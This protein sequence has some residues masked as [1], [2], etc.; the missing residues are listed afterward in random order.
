MSDVTV[1][2]GRRIRAARLGCAWSQADLAQRTGCTQT[3]ISYWEAGRREIGISDLVK[4][5]STLGVPGP[6]LLPDTPERPEPGQV[7]EALV[8]AAINGDMSR[9]VG[10]WI[11]EDV[12][13]AVL[14][15]AMP[16]LVDAPGGAGEAESDG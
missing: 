10:P 13:R 1:E 12:A 2:V 15:A 4:V 8:I 5:A 6:M 9:W 7:A 14:E 16:L 11:R 3:A